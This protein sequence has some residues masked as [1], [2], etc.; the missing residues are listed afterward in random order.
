MS[1]TSR[2]ILEPVND[3]AA[4]RALYAALAGVLAAVPFRDWSVGDDS[5]RYPWIDEGLKALETF[6]RYSPQVQPRNHA[7]TVRAAVTP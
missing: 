6:A 3:D 4:A 7:G 5:P 1:D 2:R